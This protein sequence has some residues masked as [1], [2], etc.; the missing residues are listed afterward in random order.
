MDTPIADYAVVG[1]CHGA[2]LVARD[3]S[4]DWACFGRF[5]ANPRFCRLLNGAPGGSLELRPV[6]AFTVRRR[7]LPDTTILQTTF[8]TSRGRVRL[9]DFMP[10]GRAARAGV[11]D[12]VNLRAPHWFVRV[13]EG[14]GGDV[15]LRGRYAPTASFGRRAC[16]LENRG[17]RIDDDAGGALFSSVPWRIDGDSASTGFTVRDHQVEYLVI[18]ADGDAWRPPSRQDIKKLFN[19]TG[20]FWSEWLA[21][22][23]FDGPYAEIVR[24]SALTLKLLTY[25]PSGALA[26]A[27][28]SSLPEAPG[29]SANWDYRYCWLRDGVFLLYALSVLGYSGEAERFKA[30]LERACR[31]SDFDLQIMYGLEAETSLEEEELDGVRGYL[32]S[33]PARCGNDAYRQHQL[34]VFGEV[35][36]WV[37]QYRELGGSVDANLRGMVRGVADQVVRSWR[38]PDHGFWEKRG[39]PHHHTL[40]RVMAWVALDRAIQ[41]LGSDDVLVR[42]REAIRKIVWREGISA[43]GVLKT[44]SDLQGVDGSLLLVGLLGFPCP[45]GVYERTVDRVAGELGISGYLRRYLPADD[46]PEEGA[47]LACSFWMVSALLTLDRGADARALFEQLLRGANDVG[48]YSEEIEPASHALL[49]NYPQALTHL[50]L[51]QAAVDLRLFEREGTQALAGGPSAR[52][53]R[54]VGATAGARGIWAALARTGRVGRVTSSHAS[55][56]DPGSLRA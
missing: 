17:D 8:Q 42:E 44:A 52:A 16:T 30:F 25:A 38:E 55:W 21:Y 28:T 23:R 29:G 50:A 40:G 22:S 26:A 11:H 34:D 54:A 24:R 45:D 14:L 9:T 1:D 49:G 7:Y 33:R 39:R 48:L 46:E 31:A 3:G 56:L 36:E 20:N 5:D 37:L 10:V 51:I 12:Y 2:A 35:L 53:R 32:D 18:A 41:L 15:P 47:F 43:D 6:S 4:L 19:V 27:A 13:I